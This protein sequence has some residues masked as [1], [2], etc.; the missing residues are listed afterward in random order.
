METLNR[1]R[2]PFPSFHLLQST[3]QFSFKASLLL[4]PA[5]NQAVNQKSELDLSTCLPAYLNRERFVHSQLGW[6]CFLSRA[7]NNCQSSWLCKKHSV[8]VFSYFYSKKHLEQ[9]AKNFINCSSL[10][11]NFTWMSFSLFFSNWF[12]WKKF[13]FHFQDSM[14]HTVW[15]KKEEEEVK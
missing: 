4:S 14:Y 7:K 11:F 2:S 13:N 10:W 1:A 6:I 8:L 5:Q 9:S 3:S 12:L 15:K